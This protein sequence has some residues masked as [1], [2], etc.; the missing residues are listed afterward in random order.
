MTTWRGIQPVALI[1]IDHITSMVLK[2][3]ANS[4]VGTIVRTIPKV[5]RVQDWR[6]RVPGITRGVMAR[7]RL[8]I[9]V[10]VI[11]IGVIIAAIRVV[12][13]II[14]VTMI[15]TIVSVIVVMA[16]I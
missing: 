6:T 14:I 5:R 1:I 2:P 8:V 9:A 10:I 7:P 16:V 11:V 12:I 13:P 3:P 4:V 15:V